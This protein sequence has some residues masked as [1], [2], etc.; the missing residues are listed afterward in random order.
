MQ[1]FP[2]NDNIHSALNSMHSRQ[3]LCVAE[4][5]GLNCRGQ[6]RGRERNHNKVCCCGISTLE[7][8]PR[9]QHTDLLATE[10]SSDRSGGR[11]ECLTRTSSSLEALWLSTRFSRLLCSLI[12]PLE[13]LLGTSSHPAG[14]P[15]GCSASSTGWTLFFLSPLMCFLFFFPFSSSWSR[16]SSRSIPE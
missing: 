9:M 15:R 3:E 7:S 16:G 13:C 10:G 8:R 2:C 1:N 6:K 12:T 5:R 14:A 11:E 4:A